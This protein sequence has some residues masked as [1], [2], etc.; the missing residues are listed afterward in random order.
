MT[1]PEEAWP[2]PEQRYLERVNRIEA[3]RSAVLAAITCQ[4]RES[5]AANLL[6]EA[7]SAVEAAADTVLR[8]DV[9]VEPAPDTDHLA[10]QVDMVLAEA[11]GAE[12]GELRD[13]ANRACGIAAQAV[14]DHGL[15]MMGIVVLAPIEAVPGT[16]RPYMAD[17]VG[18]MLGRVTARAI[19]DGRNRPTRPG[20]GM[21]VVRLAA[22]AEAAEVEAER[23]ADIEAGRRPDLEE[24]L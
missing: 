13:A 5:A 23:R 11:A 8:P 6:E 18:E 7:M 3:A 1:N 14:V 24:G 21:F 2:T 10:E 17:A 20:A 19:V 16:L 12:A 9:T 22:L 4:P 15:A